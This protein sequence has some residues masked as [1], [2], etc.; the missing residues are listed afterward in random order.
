M[1]I[2][3]SF[4]RDASFL[5]LPGIV[6]WILM[7]NVP[8]SGVD[9]LIYGFVALT[10]VD[11]GHVYLTLFRTYFHPEEL[12]DNRIYAITPIAIILTVTL[13]LYYHVPYFWNLVVYAT[14]WHNIRQFYGLSK[15]YQKKERR[16]CKTSIFFIYALT[17]LP[18]ILFHFRPGATAQIYSASDLF[19]FPNNGIFM[20]GSLLLGLIVVAWFSFEFLLYKKF[21]KIELGRLLSIF[22]PGFLYSSGFLLGQNLLQVLGPII[23]AHGVGYVG[24]VSFSLT[25]TRREKYSLFSK[26]IFILLAYMIFFGLLDTYILNLFIPDAPTNYDQKTRELVESLL[27]AL[28]LTPLLCHFVI[29]AFIW[30]G[31][32]RQSKL[33]FDSK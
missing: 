8:V 18:F 1:W 29:D 13:W 2:L 30:T 15:M 33:I 19:L 20:K 32:H 6:A 16:V 28:A 12:K 4:S 5:I 26:T 31:K 14:I 17:I 21:K 22:V 9:A 10:I 23:I 3:G 24:I 7:H 25:K 27:I 11:S